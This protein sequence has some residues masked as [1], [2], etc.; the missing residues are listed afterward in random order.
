MLAS[1]INRHPVLWYLTWWGMPHLTFL[2]P[3]EKNYNAFKHL[4]NKQSGLFLDVGA[5]NGVSALGFRKIVPNYKIFSIEPNALL[6]P[7]LK[8][9]QQTMAHYDYLITAAGNQSSDFTLFTAHYKGI[10]LHTASSLD[11]KFLK[12][13]LQ[14]AYPKVIF[15]NITYTSQNVPVIKLDDLFL[16]PNIIKI[17]AEGYDWE[18]LQ[19]LHRTISSYRPS[20]LIEFSFELL[21]HIIS[22]CNQIEYSILIY[23]YK[24]SVFIIFNEGRESAAHLAG[25][26]PVNLF[27]IPSEQISTLPLAQ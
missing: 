3:H 5:N 12:S 18:V 16:E 23:N 26:S 15:R 6:E 25:G 4:A 27:L 8:K 19:G 10:A 24:E 14:R 22:Y 21:T 17:D 20:V 7:S 11:L 2:L 13:S 1:L 9:R